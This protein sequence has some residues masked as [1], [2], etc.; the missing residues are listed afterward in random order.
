MFDK[1]AAVRAHFTEILNANISPTDWSQ[2]VGYS[3]VKK[4]IHRTLILPRILQ[5]QGIVV[6]QDSDFSNCVL[7]F[8]VTN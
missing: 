4:E 7:M 3:K 8:G 1:E 6:Q 2:I 5:S